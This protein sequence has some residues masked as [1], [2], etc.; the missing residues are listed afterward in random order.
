MS[1]INRG[2][3]WYVSRGVSYGSEQQAGRPAVIVSNDEGNKHSPTV[4]VVYLT[5]QPK[6]DLPTHIQIYNGGHESTVLC[7]QITTVAVERLTNYRG[8]VSSAEMDAIDGAMLISLGLL[9]DTSEDSPQ[10]LSS[11]LTKIET[12]CS[13]LRQMYDGLL[14]KILKM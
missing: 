11:R 5:T 10:V 12:E 7:E 4:E 6:K 14:N 1:Q 13:L 2:D 8:R 9:N 3:I